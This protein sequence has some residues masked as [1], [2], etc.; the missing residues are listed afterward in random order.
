MNALSL[1]IS[2]TPIRQDSEGRYCLN[3]LHKAAGSHQKHRSKYWLE[4][5]QTK[6]LIAELAEGVNPPSEQNQAVNI[7]QG[8]NRQQGTFVVKELVYAYAM[9]ISPKFHIAVIRAYDALVTGQVPR[10]ARQANLFLEDENLALHQEN[11]ELKAEVLN[12]YRKLTPVPDINTPKVPVEAVVL[13]ERYGVPRADIARVSGRNMNC[14]R[15]H[16]HNAKKAGV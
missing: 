6:D 15:Q 13:M 5:Q 4:N 2:H 9:W 16:I 8:G 10:V 3:D 14:I 1:T 7:V 12:L 11:A